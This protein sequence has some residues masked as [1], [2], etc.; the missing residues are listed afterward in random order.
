MN[1]EEFGWLVARLE[2]Q[3]ANAPRAFRTRVL[4]I[5]CAAYA[6]LALLLLLIV[7]VAGWALLHAH[8]HGIDRLV[9]GAGL[10]S[11]LAAPVL[12]VALRELLTRLPIPDGR[13]ITRT[14][15]PVLFKL[16]DK[17]RFKLRGPR[18]HHVLVDTDYNAAIAQLPRWGLFGASTNY[19]VLGLPFMI[20]QS[21]SEM[22][23]TVAHEYGHLCGAHG[24][25][26]AWVYRQRR[27]L[28]A[29]HERIAGAEEASFW[30]AAMARA[31]DFYM[32]YFNAY[33]FV[34]SRQ[35]EY[36]ADRIAA[37]LAGRETTAANLIRS[38][39]LASWFYQDF[40]PALY[41]QAN[42][43]ERPAFMPFQSMGTAFRLGHDEW[44]TGQR[45][46]A[47]WAEPSGVADTH[48]CLRER[49][50]ALGQKA[51]MPEPLARS[52]AKALLGG[53]GN[54]LIEEFDRVWWKAEKRGWT[55]RHR[56]VK[57][58]LA[59]MHELGAMPME[60]LPPH[61]LQ[62]LGL[63]HTEFDSGEQARQVLEYLLRQPGGPYPKAA[64]ALGSILIA[65]G[66]RRGLDYLAL[67]ARSDKRL[68]DD[69]LRL[70]YEFLLE[71]KGADG[72]QAWCDATM[73]PRAA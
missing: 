32:P 20:G 69:A 48:P 5:S 4:L 40:W 31:L 51:S 52:A 63:L 65:E 26:H 25:F 42:L 43:R 12:F 45:L 29:V 13:R 2:T 23:S 38:N 9:I 46:R 24:K 27:T 8:Q 37:R 54:R 10:L 70:G 19:L 14:E 39:L 56:Y 6:V 60:A 57:R 34:L 49:V 44:A 35:D 18:I 55:D 17:M 15:A 61:E 3:S 58:S 73:A 50:E 22:M 11:A 64:F 41:K 67:A 30:H 47:A 36:E 28:S 66:N 33:T 16:L 71:K 72:A 62:E 1:D 68:I 59:R 53:F 7:A 21:T